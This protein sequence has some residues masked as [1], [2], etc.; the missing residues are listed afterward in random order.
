MPSM[1]MLESR[2][3]FGP[4]LRGTEQYA[5]CPRRDQARRTQR[6]MFAPISST[7]TSRCGST[8]SATITLHAALS[9]SSRSTAPTLRFSTEAK[10][11]QQSS[12]GGGAQR[13]ARCA[14]QEAAPLQE[15]GGRTLLYVF[16]EQLP[17]SFIRLEWSSTTLFRRERSSLAGEPHVALDR[18]EADAKQASCGRLRHTFFDGSD[19]L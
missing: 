12:D 16:F 19:D 5:R 3:V 4:R 6:E 10:T 11:L 18:G 15:R 13:L 9:H 7:K 14:S 17:G 8:F 2:V 1:L